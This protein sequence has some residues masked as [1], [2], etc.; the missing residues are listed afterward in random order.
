MNPPDLSPEL[1]TEL[2]AIADKPRVT[3]YVRTTGK[4]RRA[5]D[6][7]LAE[8]RHLAHQT[9]GQKLMERYPVKGE[10]PAAVLA[11]PTFFA[12]FVSWKKAGGKQDDPRVQTM[13][14]RWQQ[15]TKAEVA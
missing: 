4:K 14:E 7:V 10:V 5:V 6:R 8:A 2:Q 15:L 11:D 9:A 12:L 13:R 1:T 3:G